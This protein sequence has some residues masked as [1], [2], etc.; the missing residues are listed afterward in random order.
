MT[1]RLLPALE[2]CFVVDRDGDGHVRPGVTGGGQHVFER[3]RRADSDEAQLLDARNRC[4]QCQ[5]L[6]TVGDGKRDQTFKTD[7][8]TVYILATRPT[9]A[10]IRVSSP[11]ET[12]DRNSGLDRDRA[13]TFGLDT[14]NEIETGLRPRV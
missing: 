14:E 2:S 1:T 13:E 8:K 12:R 3:A 9:E 5:L 4:A 10:E 7:T 11:R 6:L